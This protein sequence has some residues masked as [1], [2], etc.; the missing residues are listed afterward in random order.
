MKIESKYD[1]E[2]EIKIKEIADKIYNRRID[3]ISEYSNSSIDRTKDINRE[4]FSDITL[5]KLHECLTYIISHTSPTYYVTVENDKERER[6]EELCGR[7][8]RK[9]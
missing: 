8:I 7:S 2:T 1:K 4:L 6:M 5:N 3:I 9:G